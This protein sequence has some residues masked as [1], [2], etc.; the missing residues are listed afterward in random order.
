MGMSVIDLMVLFDYAG[1]LAPEVSGS[2]RVVDCVLEI[3]EG[4]SRL[5]GGAR[6]T[7]SCLQPFVNAFD[8]F[9]LLLK[10][11]SEVPLR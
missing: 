8:C 2:N 10:I 1:E 4:L 9:I 6:S 5:I 3:D 7:D 11:N